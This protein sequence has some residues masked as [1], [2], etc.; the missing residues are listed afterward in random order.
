MH[1]RFWLSFKHKRWYIHYILPIISKY[2]IEMTADSQGKLVL[3]HGSALPP[4]KIRKPSQHWVLSLGSFRVYRSFFLTFHHRSITDNPC[5]IIYTDL[6]LC[7]I[8]VFSL[9]LLSLLYHSASYGQEC[10]YSNCLLPDKAKFRL[11]KRPGVLVC[12]IGPVPSEWRPTSGTCNSYAET[13][14]SVSTNSLSIP[15]SG[16]KS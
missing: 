8:E 10:M 7:H 16:N 5:F 13:S 4:V 15:T 14:C 1:L 9:L 12:F 11:H 2:N 6:H 3:H